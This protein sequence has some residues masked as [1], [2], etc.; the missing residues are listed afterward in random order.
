MARREPRTMNYT[1]Q[2]AIDAIIAAVREHDERRAAYLQDPAFRQSDRE[3]DLADLVAD[4]ERAIASA[5]GEIDREAKSIEAEY[6]RRRRTSFDPIEIAEA[7]RQTRELLTAG[8]GLV[9]VVE[10]PGFTR[11]MAEAI[12][13]NART[14]LTVALGGENGELV[15]R[16]VADV[17]DR[18]DRAEVPLIF[19]RTE[20]YAT[21]REL[22]RRAAMRA[23]EAVATFVQERRAGLPNDAM[24]MLRLGHALTEDGFEPPAPADDPARRAERQRN[25]LPADL[26]DKLD[27]NVRSGFDHGPAD[28]PLTLRGEG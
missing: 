27:G 23:V 22:E 5:A 24:A 21:Q 15:E 7:W 11:T 2:R 9:D 18:V 3:R 14:H 26:R 25:S 10:L 17:L 4:R 1:I 16:S 28:V 13:R 20:Q 12:R 6:R 8:L 19:D